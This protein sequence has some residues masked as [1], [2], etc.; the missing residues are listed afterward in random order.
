LDT[1]VVGQTFIT[2]AGA[3]I[4]EQSANE[5]TLPHR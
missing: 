3:L 2:S 5:E 1:G 4:F